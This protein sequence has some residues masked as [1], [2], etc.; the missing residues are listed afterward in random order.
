LAKPENECS[1]FII[2]QYMTRSEIG[3]DTF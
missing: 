3:L 2:I 1:K